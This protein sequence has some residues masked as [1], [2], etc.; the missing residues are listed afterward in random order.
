MSTHGRIVNLD[1]PSYLEGVRFANLALDAGQG[2]NATD[3][4]RIGEVNK[5]L[6]HRQ[7]DV[8]WYHLAAGFTDTMREYIE[9]AGT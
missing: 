9:A 7:E 8:H 4:V 5:T 1:S 2:A 6:A 3:W